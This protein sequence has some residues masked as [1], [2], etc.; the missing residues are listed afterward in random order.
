MTL[1]PTL[2]PLLLL[3]LAGTPR[4][5]VGRV[6]C[7]ARGRL[8]GDESTETVAVRCTEGRRRTTVCV[9]A[10]LLMEDLEERK[11]F[12]ELLR[13]TSRGFGVARA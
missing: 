9:E 1:G 5:G 6:F 13:S 8:L 3:R 12:R 2:E 10:P 11:L 4:P 7:A